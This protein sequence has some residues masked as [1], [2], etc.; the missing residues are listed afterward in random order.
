M[1]SKPNY[2][3][4]DRTGGG[5]TEDI[6][7]ADLDEAIA[8]ARAWIEDGDW[9][10]DQ[11]R[12]DGSKTYRTVALSCCVREIVYRPN[13]SSI[14][15]LPAVYDVTVGE[16]GG[17]A[18][19]V[20]GD[21]LPALRPILAE[22]IDLNSGQ[23]DPDSEGCVILLGR[24]KGTMPTEIDEEATANGDAHDCTGR[25][26]D[27]LP[28]CEATRPSPAEGEDQQGHDWRTPHSLVGGIKENPGVWSTGGTGM[29]FDY[30]CRNCGCYKHENHPGSQR[31]PDEA[32]EAITIK[33]RDEASDAWLKR[34][35]AEDGKL[36]EWLAEM[37]GCDVEHAE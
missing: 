2:R 34:V 22:S 24:L 9:S 6:H 15:A 36:P 21:S 28:E 29:T 13:L 8:K 10:S 23:S 7:A 25:Y 14:E 5:G 33:P 19:E 11:E 12:E 4:Y 20:D 32:L 27:T 31:N 26:S 18:L 35:H 17:L 3:I 16:D 1:N 37:L 30:V